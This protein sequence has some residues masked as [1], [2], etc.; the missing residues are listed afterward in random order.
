MIFQNFE[1]TAFESNIFKFVKNSEKVK[2]MKMRKVFRL[3]C[4]GKFEILKW[5]NGKNGET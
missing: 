2:C 3:Q 1:T 4:G 5:K